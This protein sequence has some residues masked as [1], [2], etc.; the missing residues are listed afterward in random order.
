MV[1]IMYRSEYERMSNGIP[2][3]MY[4][5]VGKEMTDGP[6]ISCYGTPILEVFR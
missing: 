5:A 3:R 1:W 2:V 4:D 6:G